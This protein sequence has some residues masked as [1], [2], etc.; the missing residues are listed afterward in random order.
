MGGDTETKCGTETEGKTI[1][2]LS[3]LGI[4]P[5][6]SY[7]TQTLLWMSTSTY[8]PE[9]NIAVTWEALIVHDKYRG[10]HSQPAIE[11]STRSTMEELEK[12]P[13]ELKG[14]AVP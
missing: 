1:L 14:F 7:K 3:H 8:W 9:P 4:H 13:K 10:R 5:I 12:G 6:Y 11:L 2:R